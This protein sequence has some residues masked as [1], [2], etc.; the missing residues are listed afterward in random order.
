MGLQNKAGNQCSSSSMGSEGSFSRSF[1]LCHG[2]TAGVGALGVDGCTL[3][4]GDLED[5]HVEA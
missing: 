1:Q 3:V 4:K 2:S 5:G